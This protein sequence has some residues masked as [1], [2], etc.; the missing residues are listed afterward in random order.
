MRLTPEEAA[1]EVLEE[2]HAHEFAGTGVTRS[3][4][5]VFYNTIISSCR[6]ALQAMAE[7]EGGEESNDD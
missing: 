2:I 3:E 1:E 6:L 5:R 4:T 7:D